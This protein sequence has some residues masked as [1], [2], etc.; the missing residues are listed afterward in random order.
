MVF[1]Q[2][3]ST[4]RSQVVLGQVVKIINHATLLSLVQPYQMLKKEDGE[5]ILHKYPAST[6]LAGWKD[7]EGFPILF[8][9]FLITTS[10]PVIFLTEVSPN[11]TLTLPSVLFCPRSSPVPPVLIT[12]LPPACFT[13]SPFG[14]GPKIKFVALKKFLSEA[15]G[16]P[17]LQYYPKK[18]FTS[19]V[20]T[21]VLSSPVS[22]I[23]ALTLIVLHFQHM[24]TQ[25]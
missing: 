22:L 9:L 20:S 16:H 12:S 10:L 6:L 4:T 7:Q 21:R 14:K 18:K 25:R 24:I 23:P 2:C 3:F 5:T 1:Y 17:T 13:P 8:F 19:N 11:L 15:L